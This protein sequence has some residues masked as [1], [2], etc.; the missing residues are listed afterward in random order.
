MI[1]FFFNYLTC[2]K[3]FV[4]AIKFCFAIFLF[5]VLA[6]PIEAQTQVSKQIDHLTIEEDE[7]VHITQELDKRTEIFIKAIDRRFH[8]LNK[9]NQTAVVENQARQ[10]KKDKKDKT[11]L[12]LGELPNGST[13]QFLGDIRSILNEAVRNI[14]N[15]AEHNSK[16]PL[17]PKSLNLLAKA[18]EGFLEQLKLLDKSKLNKAE[19]RLVEDIAETSQA[20]IDAEKQQTSAVK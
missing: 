10:T 11:P 13:G 9:T 7:L 14:D 1:F 6:I 5:I 17:L 2:R 20:I 16:N 3:L 18:S 12:V 19:S 15:V 4:L 8:V